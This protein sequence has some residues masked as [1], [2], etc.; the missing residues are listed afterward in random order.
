MIKRNIRAARLA[1]RLMAAS[2]VAL[3]VSGAFAGVGLAQTA[4]AP[5]PGGPVPGGPVPGGHEV[6]VGVGK[7]RVVE[8]NGTY[9]D[10]LVADPKI[11]DVLP[12]TGHSVYIVGKGA[13]A[14]AVTILGPGKLLLTSLNVEVSADVDS[15][16][17]RLHDLLPNERDVSVQVANQSI[18]LSGTVSSP[19]AMH[20]ILELARTYVD[21]PTKVVNMM[22]VEGTQQVMLTIRFVEMSR[23]T[24]KDLT[25]NFQSQRVDGGFQHF[26]MRSGPDIIGSNGAINTA[27]AGFGAIG[28]HYLAGGQD[29]Q[30]LFDALETRGLVRTL[31]EPTLVAM[32]GD[33]ANFLAGGE[34]PIPIAQSTTAG[35]PGS[36][37]AITIE[38][39]QFGVSLGFTP[40]ILQDGMIN[41]VVNPEV[42]AIDPTTSVTSAGT[43]VPGLKV[44]RAHTTIEL[45]DGE[46]FTIAGLLEDDYLS[47]IDQMPWVGDIPVLGTLFRSTN[48]QKKQTELVI[49]VTP[50]LAVP[51]RARSATPA[52][53]FIPPSDVELF[54]AGGQRGSPS[55]LS[56]EDRV[57]LT[58]DPTK[59]GID[60][61]HGHVLY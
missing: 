22:G 54:I 21:A 3:A 46:S 31:A 4:A 42:S 37:S 47:N 51:R 19:T 52:D 61:P 13:G 60:G 57:L 10:V 7:S 59:A 39:K 24:A 34:F 53:G 12:L 14:T 11:A 9:S 30:F 18:V 55:F 2:T 5:V 20:Q 17:N 49:V 38:F 23:Q 6:V 28:L 40:T 35:V 43:T 48:Y 56:P 8:L 27:F 36:S 16:K 44:R 50:H 32:S 58:A 26:S 29:L 25:V 45:R 33:T 15:F 41:L 1:A